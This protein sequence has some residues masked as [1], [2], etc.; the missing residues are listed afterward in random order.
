MTQAS[1]ILSDTQG[2]NLSVKMFGARGDGSTDDR[3][4]I[5]EALDYIGSLTNGGSLFFPHTHAKYMVDG[6]PLIPS[7]CRLHG[8]GII[9]ILD[10]G[11]STGRSLFLD[12][13]SNVEFDG[14]QIISSNAAAR[15]SVYGNI[16]MQNASHV[17]IRN[18]S[19]TGGAST[20]IHVINSSD[21]LIAGNRI[22]DTWAD[23]IHISRGSSHVRIVD[24]YI[25]F[26]G[27]DAIGLIGYISDGTNSFPQMK[28]ITVAKNQIFNLTKSVGRGIS[29]YGVVGAKI[30]ENDIDTVSDAGIIVSAT[31]G[32][33]PNTATHCSRDVVISHNRVNGAGA[34]SMGLRTGIFI[35]YCRGVKCHENAVDNSPADGISVSFAVK[36]VRVKDNDVSRSGGR[37]VIAFS[38][39]SNDARLLSEMFTDVGETA[40][41]S[42]A[43][44][45]TEIEN[46]RVRVSGGYG[47]SIERDTLETI[48]LT[49][50]R[51]VLNKVFSATTRG[52]SIT[53]A[54]GVIVDGN[55]VPDSPGP[56]ILIGSCDKPKARGNTIEAAAQ[57]GLG[58]IGCTNPFAT[59]NYVTGCAAGGIFS[60][61][62]TTNPYISDNDAFGNTTF[63]VL[64]DNTGSVSFHGGMQFNNFGDDT[65]AATQ[66][67][68]QRVILHRYG[69]AFG[70]ITNPA[71][72]YA[73]LIG[74]NGNPAIGFGAL[75][76]LWVDL[77]S[78]ALWNKIT[79]GV[80]TFWNQI[81]GLWFTVAGGIRTDQA[82]GIKEDPVAG[83]DL[84]V[85]GGVTLTGLLAS[86]PLKLDSSK[87][88]SAAKIF[89]NSADDI[90]ASALSTNSMLESDGSV[91]IAVPAS[92]ARTHL[93][94]YS[95]AEVDA[96]LAAKAD[97][98]ALT[99][100]AATRAADDNTLN[101]NKADHNTYG[102][103][104]DSGGDTVS[105]TI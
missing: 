57:Y 9:D 100:E 83:S 102:P 7:N 65:V 5:Q 33:D 39:A 18:C 19:I 30:T 95:K 23:G 45:E 81:A 11:T 17:R 97:A 98:S 38:K 42:M 64:I 60:D 3:A 10:D 50:M 40:P 74:G 53:D 80:T 51:A 4:A 103:F 44:S 96:L 87:K 89:P 92:T 52:I 88:I 37:G 20:G 77:V 75:G 29:V 73:V 54:D 25:Y 24:N 91:I 82:V 13:V 1:Q 67:Y 86:R 84:S 34:G 41:A 21:L 99:A 55:E 68:L 16:R 49:G 94:V 36:D 31:L 56:G 78:G 48:K 58:F 22:T 93:S 104:T 32:T 76:W 62:N 14:L 105:I 71:T 43:I 46:N 63:D 70:S 101:T 2:D 85:A 6:S 69:L 26:V 59:K 35:S 72:D 90:D 8:P 15:T 47:I 28:D 12:G 79:D 61:L 66:G 27:D